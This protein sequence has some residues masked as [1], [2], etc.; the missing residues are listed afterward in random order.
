MITDHLT[1]DR[2]IGGQRTDRPRKPRARPVARV[3]GASEKPSP[4]A[5]TRDAGAKQIGYKTCYLHYTSGTY[6]TTTVSRAYYLQ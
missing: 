5:G 2:T 1:I 6:L 3:L 4:R